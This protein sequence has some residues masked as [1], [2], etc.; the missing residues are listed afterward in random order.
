MSST[1]SIALSSSP[2]LTANSRRRQRLSDLERDPD[3]SVLDERR[4]ALR[5]LLIKPLILAGDDDRLLVTRHRDWLSLWL[6][7]HVGWDLHLDADCARLYKRPAHVQDSTR[8]CR[9]PASKEVSLTRRGYVFLTLTL[10]ILTREERQLTLN[11]LA[12]RLAGYSQNEP[13]FTANGLPLTLDHRDARRDLVQALR[14]LLSWQVLVRI[15]GSEDSFVGD[16]TVDVLYTINRSVLSVLLATRQPPSLIHDLDL[17]AR[18]EKSWLGSSCSIES[19]DWATR[20]IRFGL[21]RR[22]LDDP[23]LY[24]EDLTPEERSYFEKQRT[25]ILREIEVA[26]GLIA[27]VRTEGVAMVDRTSDLS[28]YSLP[29]T[30]TDGHLTLL[31]ATSLAARLRQGQEEAI[32]IKEL[33]KET[34]S[35]ARKQ[36]TW[37]KDAR[38]PGSEV[39][40]TRDAIHR[41]EALGLVKCSYEPHLLIRPRP[42]IARFALHEPAPLPAS[43]LLERDLFSS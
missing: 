5:A 20:Q 43:A 33:E 16:Q 19:D 15:D 12:E 37:R 36:T 35:H 10:G 7:H 39:A 9:D 17:E 23:V 2:G 32:T 8:P 30:G 28:D 42:A 14:V 18:L 38:Q 31:L 29:E 27:E 13:L 11:R 6:S 22:L 24:Y 25:F 26:T 4:Q 41:L 1:D 40:L 3:P 21:F 34:A